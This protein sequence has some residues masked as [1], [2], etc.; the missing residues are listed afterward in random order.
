MKFTA[1]VAVIVGIFSIPAIVQGEVCP[2]CACKPPP[3]C[4]PPDVPVNCLVCIDY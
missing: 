3:G 1:I 2:D 4:T